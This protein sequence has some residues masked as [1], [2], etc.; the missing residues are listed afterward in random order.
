MLDDLTP[1]IE[2]VH[3]A[4]IVGDYDEA[5]GTIAKSKGFSG[6][7]LIGQLGAF[8]TGLGVLSEFFQNRDIYREPLVTN[9]NNKA[10]FFNNI[11]LCLT[12][13]GRP[14]QA[15]PF[16]E[17]SI[18]IDLRSKNRV[19]CSLGYR[20]LA[21]TYSCLG[22][23][24]LA[25]EASQN[26]LSF[27]RL[28]GNTLEKITSIGCNAW[29]SYLSGDLIA[30]K[31]DFH[32]AETIQKRKYQRN[33]YLQSNGIKYATY[34]FKVGEL[35]EARKRA[36]YNLKYAENQH[37]NGDISSYNRLL[38]D[39]DAERNDYE[40]ANLHYNEAVRIARN[41]S[42]RT[43]LIEAL[44]SRGRFMAKHM[45]NT[46]GAFCDLNEALGLATQSGYRIYEADIRVAMA[47]AHFSAE[48]TRAAKD[49]AEKAKQM[50]VQMGYHWGMI[51]SDEVLAKIQ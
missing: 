38:G 14:A 51:D 36:E 19:F 47:W 22:S 23:L 20:N 50:S 4:C 8:E 6:Y 46:Q 24:V 7:T 32:Q 37:L 30:A 1:L 10:Y 5:F 33:P 21:D 45:S 25:K 2:Y 31:S 43:L 40:I 26:S 11:G 49:E 12:E 28:S 41:G 9:Y 17:R 48:N 34:L 3:Y 27:A 35:E 18:K 16:F 15:I 39:V 29:I 44:A 42:S 13:L